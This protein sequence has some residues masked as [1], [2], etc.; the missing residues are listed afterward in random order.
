MFDCPFGYKSGNE[1]SIALDLH[2]PRV[3]LVWG[4]DSVKSTVTVLEEGDF[5]E[6]GDNFD[7]RGCF[8]VGG[9]HFLWRRGAF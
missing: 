7:W 8:S 1:T 4:V 3:P 5:T 9:Y 2:Y 6:E